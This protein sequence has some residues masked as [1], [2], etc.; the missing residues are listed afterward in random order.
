[1]S[2]PAAKLVVLPALKLA[3]W[4]VSKAMPAGADRAMSGL[5]QAGVWPAPPLV[6]DEEDAS[7]L[8]E[9]WLLFVMLHPH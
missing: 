1:M 8:G 2:W 6:T 4:G 7:S 3:D 5:D 9:F